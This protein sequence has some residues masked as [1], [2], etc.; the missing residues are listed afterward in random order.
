M[1]ILI[2]RTINYY[3][4]SSKEFIFLFIFPIVIMTAQYMMM[5]NVFKSSNDN[6]HRKI[7]VYYEVKKDGIISEEILNIILKPLNGEK[8]NIDNVNTDTVLVQI[9]EEEIKVIYGS[10]AEETADSIINNINSYARANRVLEK[11][12]GIDYRDINVITDYIKAEKKPESKDYYGVSMM[13]IFLITIGSMCTGLISKDKIKGM[14][15]RLITI[16]ISNFKYYIGTMIGFVVIATIGLLPCYIYSYFVLKTNWGGNFLIPYLSL[17]PFFVLFLSIFTLVT[18]I[19]E[20][21]EKVM[22]MVGGIAF[23]ILGGLGGAFFPVE[24]FVPE[25]FNVICYVSPLKW[26]NDGIFNMVYKT[27]YTALIIAVIVSTFLG[28]VFT[29]MTIIYSNRKERLA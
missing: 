15:D 2:K 8:G 7:K 6:L 16:G 24:N 27:E 19:F 10:L 5:E 26:Y 9:N 20:N 12:N 14:K 29:S 4:K 18:A 25:W 21:G 3:F 1:W 28:I 23:P 22:G 11:T 13:S 17:I